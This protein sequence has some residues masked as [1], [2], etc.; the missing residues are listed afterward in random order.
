MRKALRTQHARS[1]G[2]TAAIGGLAALLL[3]RPAAPALADTGER[4]VGSHRWLAPVMLYA[5]ATSALALAGVAGLALHLF[6]RRRAD[7]RDSAGRQA[8][9]HPQHQAPQHQD[10]QH[11]DPKDDDWER[12]IAMWEQ[13]LGTQ[14]PAEDDPPPPDAPPPRR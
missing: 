5:P 7:K 10:P 12:R 1:A 2:R 11:Q 4:A 13:R 14:H 6:R 8:A 3:L 9:S